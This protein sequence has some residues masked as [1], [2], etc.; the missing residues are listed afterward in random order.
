MTQIKVGGGTPFIIL[1]KFREV[2]PPKTAMMAMRQ[3]LTL[4]LGAALVSGCVAAPGSYPNYSEPYSPYYPYYAP[5]YDYGAD[6]WIGGGYWDRWGHGSYRWRHGEHDHG[7]HGHGREHHG[8][9]R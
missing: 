6:V 8:G 7:D 4:T 5:Y 3:L 2:H 1:C 9:R